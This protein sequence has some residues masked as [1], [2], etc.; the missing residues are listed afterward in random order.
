MLGD[1]K[2]IN[3]AKD[4]DLLIHDAQFTREQYTS[5]PTPRQGFGHSIPEM[6]I[7]VGKAAGAKNLVLTH[8]DPS[9]TDGQ[10]KKQQSK[11]KRRFKNLLYAREGL[12][13]K[14]S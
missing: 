13:C 14:I 5:L 4:T 10:I 9:A 1:T 3:F 7:E 12:T 8:H 11:Y 6:A 2:L